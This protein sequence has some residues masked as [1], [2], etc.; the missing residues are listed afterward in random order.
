LTNIASAFA[1]RAGDDKTGILADANTRKAASVM[2]A[3]V[4]ENTTTGLLV[5]DT[6]RLNTSAATKLPAL[7]VVARFTQT[8]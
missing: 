6:I 3:G 2:L 5:V 8:A 4:D 1:A 7:P